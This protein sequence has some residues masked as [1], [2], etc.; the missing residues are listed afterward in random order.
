MPETTRKTASAPAA[1]QSVPGTTPGTA[2]ATKGD[3][4]TA[5][6]IAIGRTPQERARLYEVANEN[7]KARALRKASNLIATMEWGAKLTD[8]GRA[9]FARYCLEL[10]GDPLRHVDIL[11]GGPFINGDYYRDVIA[12]NPAFHHADDPIWIHDDP[13]L[14][15]CVLCGEPFGDKPDHGHGSELVT[16][17]NT[18][19]LNERVARAMKRIDEDVPESDAAACILLLHY[20]D[21][22]GPFKGIGRARGG[23]VTRKRKDG[24]QYTTSADPVGQESPRE[25]A[26]TRAWREAGEKAEPVWFR[27]HSSKKEAAAEMIE[28]RTSGRLVEADPEPPTPVATDEPPAIEAVT[29]T[30]SFSSGS[31]E[32]VIETDEDGVIAMENHNPTKICGTVGPHP[33]SEC[34][35]Q[36]AKEK[37]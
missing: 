37:K 20:S 10:G 36:K 7:A 11:A 21:G 28:L 12:A 29:E 4:E 18:R 9:A 3:A 30:A 35:Y 19:R 26:E 25:T 16:E 13:R 27:N 34:G 1:P 24:S 2:L 5:E 31:P 15:L 14:K 6:L 17:E 32:Q 23:D 22:R 8:A 33:R